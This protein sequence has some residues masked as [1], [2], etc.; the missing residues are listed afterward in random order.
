MHTSTHGCRSLTDRAADLIV[1]ETRLREARAQAETAVAGHLDAALA[2]IED[3]L[4][5]L[6]APTD[7]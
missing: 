3:A 2:N 5:A 6:S 1:I 4:T 7:Q